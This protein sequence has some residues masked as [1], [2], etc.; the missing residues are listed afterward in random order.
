MPS[1]RSKLLVVILRLLRMKRGL[2]QLEQRVARGEQTSTQPTRRQRRRHRITTETVDGHAVWSIAHKAGGNGKYIF[3]L[4]GGAYV[5]SFASQHWG[6]ISKLVDALGCTVVAPDYPH[7]PEHS[8]PATIGLVQK[9]YQDTAAQAGGGDRMTIMGGSSGGGI[10]VALALRIRDE[11]LD[12]PRNLVL[13]SPWLDATLSNSEVPAFD[14]I[15]PFLDAAGL[16][17]AGTTYARDL[18][19]GS[20]LVSPF[21]TNLKGLAPITLFIGTRD[22]LLPDC[23]R[24]KQQAEASG[25]AIDYHEYEGMVHNW[26]LVPLPESKRVFDTIVK[27]LRDPSVS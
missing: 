24:L 13:L 21:S 25:A 22:L 27:T 23:R 14:R 5:N 1:L 26:M 11:G 4:H 9:V 3:Y 6:F 18:D 17:W 2:N 16:R 8:A 12:Q 19:P 10:G 15:D 20:Y 7:T